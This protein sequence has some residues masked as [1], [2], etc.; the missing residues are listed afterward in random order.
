LFEAPFLAV[1]RS[2]IWQEETQAKLEMNQNTG[3]PSSPQSALKEVPASRDQKKRN[4]RAY[5]YLE[6]AEAKQT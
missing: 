2:T 5:A 6:A 4:E 1:P 3:F